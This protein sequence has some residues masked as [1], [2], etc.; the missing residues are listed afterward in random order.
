[1]DT[2]ITSIETQEEN[3]F[4]QQRHNGAKAWI[5]LNDIASEGTF[6][7]IDGCLSDFTYW[8]KNQPNNLA[9][10][11]DCVHTLGVKFKYRWN[12]V[13]CNACHQYT[14]EKGILTVQKL[15]YIQQ[16]PDCRYFSYIVAKLSFSKTRERL[17]LVSP[18]IRVHKAPFSPASPAFLPRRHPTRSISI[19]PVSYFS[20]Y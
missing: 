14:C 8:Q 16:V 1:M 15:I 10:G 5:G 18:L 7:W 13:D 2:S 4:V 17:T 9:P 3:V 6:A 12:D 20:S 11:Q 19:S